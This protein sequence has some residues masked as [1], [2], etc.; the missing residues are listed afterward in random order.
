MTLLMTLLMTLM[1]MMILLCRAIK[2]WWRTRDNKEKM[3]VYMRWE[4]DYDLE[5]FGSLNIFDQYLEIGIENVIMK[6]S[7]SLKKIVFSILLQNIQLNIGPLYSSHS[8]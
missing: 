1:M 2:K 6:Y 5:H 7:C 8:Q 3:D 4:Q